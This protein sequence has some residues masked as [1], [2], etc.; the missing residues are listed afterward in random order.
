[1]VKPGF[2]AR[3]SGLGAKAVKPRDMQREG[4]YWTDPGQLR[5]WKGEERRARQEPGQIRDSFFRPLL[6]NDSA[7]TSLQEWMIHQQL[8]FC[9]VI[10]RGSCNQ[11]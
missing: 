3:Q 11:S 7:V 1:M 5:E 8:Y 4:V 9:S 10:W 2:E 6:S